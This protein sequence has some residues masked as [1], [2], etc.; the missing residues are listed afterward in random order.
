MKLLFV[1]ITLS[2]AS[3]AFAEGLP[4]DD[5]TLKPYQYTVAQYVNRC[6]QDAS[7]VERSSCLYDRYKEILKKINIEYK[8]ALIDADDVGGVGEI[9]GKPA[10]T[11]AKLNRIEVMRTQA[12]WKSYLDARCGTM[13]ASA[14]R[15]GAN[16]AGPAVEMAQCYIRLTVARLNELTK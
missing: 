3:P 8:K 12:A 14:E 2:L 15:N 1:A 6:A 7:N 5:P 4:T 13:G 9:N 16:G 10:S 11:I